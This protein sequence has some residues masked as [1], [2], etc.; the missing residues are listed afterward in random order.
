M[1]WR[2]DK[3]RFQM[4]RAKEDI[5]VYKVLL[6]NKEGDLVSAFFESFPWKQGFLYKSPLD[7]KL[8]WHQGDYEFHGDQGLHSY[9]RKPEYDFPTESYNYPKS[10]G[11]STLYTSGCF[12]AKCIIP[13]GYSFCVN[14]D[15]EVISDALKFIEIINE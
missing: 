14:E 6:K 8:T 1:C 15:G 2:C 5:E 7:I 10:F 4:Q 11:P 13:K 9:I 12:L 3:N